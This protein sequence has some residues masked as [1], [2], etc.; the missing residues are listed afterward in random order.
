M[1]CKVNRVVVQVVEGD[2]Q[3]ERA[4]GDV[5]AQHNNG[6]APDV[7]APADSAVWQFCD[8]VAGILLANAR[9]ITF[10]MAMINS[11]IQILIYGFSL[12]TIINN[13]SPELHHNN[14]PQV[15]SA[16]CYGLSKSLTL[17]SRC[18]T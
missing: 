9:S 10:V 15:H 4:R 7:T 14:Y 2:E 11:I 13:Y 6:A 3:V 8:R 12:S 1:V 16:H 17:I 18:S 5:E